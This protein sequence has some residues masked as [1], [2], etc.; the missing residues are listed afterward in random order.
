MLP[1]RVEDL[2]KIV[3]ENRNLVVKVYP[4]KENTLTFE[5]VFK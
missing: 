1:V 5:G 3:E 2:R 4:D